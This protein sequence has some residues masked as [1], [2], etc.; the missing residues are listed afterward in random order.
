MASKRLRRPITVWLL[1]N[2]V[3]H[4]ASA[5]EQTITVE[6]A[7]TAALCAIDNKIGSIGVK[8]QLHVS[9]K[10]AENCVWICPQ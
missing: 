10:K 9:S 1:W 2:S 7:S 8:V 3:L 6:I 4:S 5:A